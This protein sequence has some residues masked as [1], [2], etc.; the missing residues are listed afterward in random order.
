MG[1]TSTSFAPLNGAANAYAE[2]R[3]D[4]RASP[5]RVKNRRR[6]YLDLHPEYFHNDG[7][8][9]ADPLLYDRLVRRFMT[10]EERET[11]G[12][13][14][15]LASMLEANLT[16][17]EAKIEALEHPDPDDP[18][19]YVKTDDGTIV[20]I[21]RD[22]AARPDNRED[23]WERWKDYITQKFLQGKDEDADYTAIDENEAYDDSAE[24]DRGRLERYTDAQE[25]QFVGNASPMGETG[26]QDF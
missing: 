5:T 17:S 8:E 24:E 4:A 18:L 26:V 1:S 20:G 11:H 6:R 10:T 7:R 21:E 13:D 9:L 23:A 2:H 14:R 16:R 22:E 12:Q 15:S 3:D 19:V 25:E